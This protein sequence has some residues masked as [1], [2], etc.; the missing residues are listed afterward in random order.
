VSVMAGTIFQDSKLP[1]TVWFRAM[2][3]LTSQNNGVS[4]L[5]R[6]RVLGLGSYKTAWT[7]L[8]KLRRASVR[9]WR[10]RARRVLFALTKGGLLFIKRD[11]GSNLN[12]CAVNEILENWYVIPLNSPVRCPQYNGAVENAKKRLGRCP[13]SGGSRG[14]RTPPAPRHPRRP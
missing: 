11:N 1:L 8:H 4:A 13:R 14:V 7:A 5:G 3:H 10:D 9:R 6:Q 12:S 2:W